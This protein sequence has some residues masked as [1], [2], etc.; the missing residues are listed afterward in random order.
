MH[1]KLTPRLAAELAQF[2][3]RLVDSAADIRRQIP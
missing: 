3:Y 1:S 2:A